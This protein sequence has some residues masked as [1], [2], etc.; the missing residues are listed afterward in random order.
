LTNWLAPAFGKSRE[1]LRLVPDLD[2]VSALAAERESLWKRVNEATFLTDDERRAAVG[3]APR[4]RPERRP[5]L[6]PTGPREGRPDDAGSARAG[7]V[8]HQWL[9][10]DRILR[11]SCASRGFAPL[12]RNDGKGNELASSRDLHRA[13][14]SRASR[15]L[16]LGR[17]RERAARAGAARAGGGER[18][19]DDFV[20]ELARFNA[21]HGDR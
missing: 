7:T 17:G 13:R 1:S 5:G 15:A 18:R 8:T 19:F 9:C 10:D 12:A 16:S 6:E 21:R 4:A 20:R 2:Q 14:R 11:R 3:Y